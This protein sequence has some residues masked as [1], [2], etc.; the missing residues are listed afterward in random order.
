MPPRQN[1][2]RDCVHPTG[3]PLSRHSVGRKRPRTDVI[4]TAEALPWRGE[5]SH[6]NSDITS[7][8]TPTPSLDSDP[9]LVPPPE[10]TVEYTTSLSFH[11]SSLLSKSHTGAASV[12]PASSAYQSQVGT[13]PRK[14]S[15]AGDMEIEE[16]EGA[17]TSQDRSSQYHKGK[18]SP[19]F[20]NG[21]IRLN[22]GGTLFDTTLTTVLKE[23]PSRLSKDFYS[24]FVHCPHDSDGNPYYDRDPD[25]FRHVLNY[26]RGYPLSLEPDA[27]VM[28]SED[29]TYY[30]LEGLKKA[31][32]LDPT[33]VVWRFHPGPGVFTPPS[34][35]SGREI[36]NEADV[37]IGH[38]G[39]GRQAHPPYSVTID[40]PASFS[41]TSSGLLYSHGDGRPMGPQPGTHMTA[42]S[43]L[44]YLGPGPLTPGESVTIF[45]KI[46]RCVECAIGIG[47]L[48]FPQNLSFFDQQKPSTAGDNTVPSQR[49]VGYHNSGQITSRLGNLFVME[50]GNADWIDGG[51]PNENETVVDNNNA[52]NNG[53]E[54]GHSSLTHSNTVPPEERRI[55]IEEV[56]DV[57]TDR[58][59]FPQVTRHPTQ[60]Q[61]NN[62]PTDDTNTTVGSSSIDGSRSSR[63][64]PS[65]SVIDCEY[66]P[67]YSRVL[68]FKADEEV[69]M[70][71]DLHHSN[72]SLTVRFYKVGAAAVAAAA[73]ENLSPSMVTP[74]P[75]IIQ[76]NGVHTQALLLL[77][78]NLQSSPQCCDIN[79]KDKMISDDEDT[80]DNNDSSSTV[81]IIE[82]KRSRDPVA[83]AK[84]KY[85]RAGYNHRRPFPPLQPVVYISG[86]T[87]ISTSQQP[88][89]KQSSVTLAT[90]ASLLASNASRLISRVTQVRMTRDG[91]DAV[92]GDSTRAAPSGNQESSTNT[93][94]P[95][96]VADAPVAEWN[97]QSHNTESHNNMNVPQR[98]SFRPLTVEGD[99][100]LILSHSRM[101][102]GDSTS[103]NNPSVTNPAE[104]GLSLFDVPVQSNNNNHTSG[105]ID[106][107]DLDTL[108]G[109]NSLQNPFSD[110]QGSTASTVIVEIMRDFNRAVTASSR[111]EAV[112]T[113]DDSSVPLPLQGSSMA[114]GGNAERGGRAYVTLHQMPNSTEGHHQRDVRSLRDSDRGATGAPTTDRDANI[115]LL[116]G[117]WV[118]DPSIGHDSSVTSY[119]NN[120]NDNNNND[121]GISHGQSTRI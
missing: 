121:R 23:V 39:P 120:N 48:G 44:S 118:S 76:A 68:G 43:M 19:V 34:S 63:H 88:F 92:P 97:S 79:E 84:K 70:A 59:Q 54:G 46:D 119:N 50:G 71:V 98:G 13:P 38:V 24:G 10:N 53:G 1:I 77:E 66:M 57:S 29:A 107:N 61:Q 45:F 116:S 58:V 35:V 106:G 74:T 86:N 27:I 11:S 65:L 60:G 117:Q 18:E 64:V 25:N 101:P 94:A 22:V 99:Y 14:G 56:G 75:T 4:P 96:P 113:D 72:T 55:T 109:D 100:D 42:S 20:A 102:Q 62:S 41:S 105:S 87:M 69:C 51:D 91:G 12:T 40:P 67:H 28:L 16:A 8:T 83:A 108:S 85:M 47:E 111:Y 95:A 36:T 112:S 114:D 115:V 110:V 33:A 5:E 90:A 9:S 2:K 80:D 17:L 31:V 93:V 26:L 82:D 73:T 52:N 89:N 81:V 104:H 49:F 37:Q 32:G 21:C 78:L 6:H 15:K 30:E 7:D 3:N 103:Q